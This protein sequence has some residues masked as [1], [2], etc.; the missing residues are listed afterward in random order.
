MKQQKAL[1][2]E[3]ILL[4][5]VLVLPFVSSAMRSN[6]Q[7]VQF[8]GTQGG[9]FDE[10]MCQQGQDFLIQIAPFGC[11]PAVV[12][13]DLLEEQNVPVFCQLG[14]TKINPL[15]DVEA[16]ESISFS[17]E[18]PAEVEGIAFHPA[19]AALGIEGDLTNPLLNNIGYVVIV[20]K[21]QA[22]ASAMPDYIS[23]ELT[24]RIKYDVKNAFGIGKANFY[25]P[26][27]TDNEWEI[28]KSQYSFWSGKGSLRAESIEAD[29][30]TISIYSDDRK[31]SSVSLNKGEE[32][33][34]ISLPG[35]ECSASLQVKLN[36]LENPDTR[37]LLRIN[38]NVVE[39]A[40]GEKF[41]ENKCRVISLEKQGLVQK[42]KIR[43]TEDDGINNFDLE[44]QPRV[45]LKIGDEEPKNYKIGDIIH[46]FEGSEKKIFLSYI[47]QTDEGDYF[48]VPVVSPVR[49]SEEFL[50]SFMA[51]RLPIFIKAFESVEGRGAIVGIVGGAIVAEYG[52]VTAIITAI[53]TGSYPLAMYAKGT[54]SVG[55]ANALFNFA[56]LFTKVVDLNLEIPKIEFVDFADPQDIILEG[57]PQKYYELAVDDYETI[58]ESFSGEKY[59]NNMEG[60]LDEKALYEQITLASYVQQ[61]ARVIELCD[62]FRIMYP[63]SDENL[64]KCDDDY[65]LSNQEIS[66]G[67]VT[68]NGKSKEIIFD[69]IY[70][71]STDDYSAE[72]FVSGAGEYNGEKTLRK[73]GDISLSETES[74]F[75][76]ELENDYAIFDV[77]GVDYGPLKEI[78]YDPKN[79]KIELGEYEIVGKKKYKISLERINLKKSA[80]VTLSPSFKDSGTEASFGFNIGIEQRAFELSP[81][82]IKE[83]IEKLDA[84]LSKWQNFS[85][86]LGNVVKGLKVACL[87]TGATLTVKNFLAN[88]GGR[89]IARKYIMRGSGGWYEQCADMVNVQKYISRE[90]CLLGEADNIEIDVDKLSELISE[91]NEQIQD[92][93]VDFRIEN[94]GN[95]AVN[96]SGFMEEYSEK[97]TS[98]W[99]GSFLESFPDPDPDGNGETIEKAEMIE[100]LSYEGWQ[101]RNY[102]REQLREIE[103]WAKVLKDDSASEDLQKMAEK[104]LYS[105]LLGIQTN[106]NNYVEISGWAGDF[107]V[108]PDKFAFVETDE[109]AERITYEGLTYTNIKGKAGLSPLGIEDTMPVQFLQTSSGGTY[110]LV[111][112]DFSGTGRMPIKRMSLSRDEGGGEALMV[113]D[114]QGNRIP[115]LEIPPVVRNSY[116]QKYDSSSYENRYKN[117]ELRYYETE[118]YKGLPAI[119]PFDLDDG[120]YVATKQTLPVF[121][122]IGAYTAAGAANSVWLGNVGENGLEENL[123]GDDIYQMINLGTGQPLNQFPG[124]DKNEASKVIRDA[125]R[126]ILE[127]S[128]AYRSG[129]SGRVNILGEGIKVGRPAINIPEIECADLMSVKDCQLLFNVCDPVICPSSR[130]DLGGAYPVRDVIQTGIIGSLAL[131]LPNIQEGIFIPVCLTG[132]QAGI[133]GWLSVKESYRDCL[134][135]SLE[136]GEMIGIC[137]EIH[138][139]YI[140]EFFWRQALPLADLAIPKILGA[141]VGQNVRRGGE[142]LSVQNAWNTAG[143]SVTYFT[144]YYGANSI[145]AFKS[146]STEEVGTEVCK[147]SVSAVYSSGVDIIDSLTEPDSPSQFH[148]RFDEI[149]FS[150]VTSPPTSHYKVFYHVYAGKDS[151]AYYQVYLKGIPGSSYYQDTSSTLAIASGYIET[152]GYASETRD[153]TAVSGYQQLCINVN[154]QEECGFSEVSSSFAI[155]YISDEYVAW[156]VKNVDIKT[157]SECVGNG[158]VGIVGEGELGIAGAGNVGI[159]RI[160]ATDNPG[161]GSDRYAGT[162]NS[163]W[164][165]VGNCGTENILCWLDTESVK[166]VIDISTIEEEALEEVTDNYLDFLR[167]QEGYLSEG[168]FADEVKNI[169]DAEA[170]EQLRLIEKIFDK[171]FLN[172]EKAYLFLL[173]GNAYAELA[174]NWWKRATSKDVGGER[175][176]DTGE[177][178]TEEEPG[179]G[180]EIQIEEEELF[181]YAD[182]Y[183]RTKDLFEK[184]SEGEYLPDDWTGVKFRSLLVAIAIR[185]SK[186][187][188]PPPREIYDPRWIMEFGWSGGER[189]ER[190]ICSDGVDVDEI[191]EEE[192]RRCAEVQIKDA[193][194]ILKLALNKMNIVSYQK[195]N[196]PLRGDFLGLAPNNHLRCVLSVYLTGQRSRVLSSTD[197]ERYADEIIDLMEFLEDY[198]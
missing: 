14:A 188:Y 42:V 121:G 156:Q 35:F 190:Y 72:I 145:Q 22:N 60:T 109:N 26:E 48:I 69:G 136:T 179:E 12:R 78:A 101:N 161:K 198:F 25:L 98:Y 57:D 68:I 7:Y 90:Q 23:G 153:L 174:R 169:E 107:G 41:L 132:V 74:I 175:K 6:P 100:I 8:M 131:C 50:D 77:S 129:M 64:Q 183:A 67:Y 116:F 86:K 173:R 61:K 82:K 34:D 138:S 157:E 81:D 99:D 192:V 178:D 167:E 128:N 119:V 3:M 92:L 160:C 159:L 176:E 45:I 54:G 195:C 84:E 115:D 80:K 152:G 194:N 95:S 58:V 182:R 29:R 32:S 40:E 24:A 19:R 71:P 117:P 2:I 139:V 63:D 180:E 144:Q 104:E 123:G 83:R 191:D 91:Q 148:G 142:Y 11:T 94:F 158:N 185:Q 165:E 108:D 150:S 163:R 130:C 16:I 134:Q 20:L 106:A 147:L 93:E 193:A 17:G 44:I 171:V 49:T 133:D 75:L 170:S 146:R 10:S 166:D 36:S 135:H 51:K 88:A 96:T 184:Y 114:L 164:R 141:L 38:A 187:G 197:G 189:I 9:E 79:L 65:K 39:V 73:N 168:V 31:I 102:N 137:D 143:D 27:M 46:E 18:Y 5:L 186:L 105:V 151:G 172:N 118:P 4:L 21:K 28:K 33:D 126:A 122:N 13:S 124:L 120:W 154:G 66:I 162:E 111:L 37:A 76:K 70:E 127:A 177:E 59:P 140:C 149:P 113:Y 47:G 125:Q 181:E 103:L 1:K 89:G 87:A 62:E 196:G 15:I 112:D 155:D 52:M 43:C 97:V 56:N 55:Y 30:A 53:A 110:I 85:N